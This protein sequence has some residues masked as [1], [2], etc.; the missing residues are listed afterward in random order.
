MKVAFFDRDG[1]IIADYPDHEWSEVK[2]P[3]FIDGAIPTNPPHSY[4]SIM[5]EL[6]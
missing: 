1:T 4:Q 5:I 3:V 2:H 6:H